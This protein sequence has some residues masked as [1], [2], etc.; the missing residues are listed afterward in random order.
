MGAQFNMQQANPFRWL[1]KL[2]RHAILAAVFLAPMS[3]LPATVEQ[4]QAILDQTIQEDGP[5]H[6][7]VA[8]V[9]NAMALQL[10]R[11]G[12]YAQA[13]T[14]LQRALAIR[15]KALGPD[16]PDVATSLNNLAKVLQEQGKDQQ[17]TVSEAR[18]R[19]RAGAAFGGA[20]EVETM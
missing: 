7:N 16:H 17:V 20:T 12:Q 13:L 2:I 11:Q 19:A 5:E 6:A 14:Q 10:Y 18:A 8:D 3:V 9:L 4:L 15:E 1:G